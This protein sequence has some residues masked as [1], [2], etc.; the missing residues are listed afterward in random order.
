MRESNQCVCDDEMIVWRVNWIGRSSQNHFAP[1]LECIEGS[2]VISVPLDFGEEFHFSISGNKKCT[3]FWNAEK[4]H[5][6]CPTFSDAVSGCQCDDCRSN[7]FMQACIACDGSVCFAPSAMRVPCSLAEYFV[8]LVSFGDALKVGITA[9]HR[10]PQRCIEQ[11]ADFCTA[12]ALVQGGDLV[13]CIEKDISRDFSIADR[14]TTSK[15]IATMTHRNPA[16]IPEIASS[17]RES[18]GSGAVNFP[19]LDLSTHHGFACLERKPLVQKNPQD[20][21][22]G[23]IIGVKGS[24]G[25]FECAASFFAVDFKSL[26]GRKIEFGAKKQNVQSSL[27]GWN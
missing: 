10:Y 9:K 8:Y 20:N 27:F 15:K 12:V 6:P 4:K 19:V 22:G 1:V 24:T 5:Q 3:G 7:D 18:V 21:T 25:V 14:M 13:R 2:E 17:V 16:L 26:S 23:K 11:G